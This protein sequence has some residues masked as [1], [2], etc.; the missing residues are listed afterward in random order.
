MTDLAL[1]AQQES[2]GQVTERVRVEQDPRV[3]R[4]EMLEAAR[5][6]IE[7][8]YHLTLLYGTTAEGVC[9]CRLGPRCKSAGKHPQERA[10]HWQ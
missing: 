7:R 2:G 3:G 6:F 4:Q 9:E 5:A 1:A 8:G 10:S